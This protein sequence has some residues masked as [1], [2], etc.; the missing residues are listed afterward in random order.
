MIR[1]VDDALNGSH[2]AVVDV[3]HLP[4]FLA[5]SGQALTNK[6]TVDFGKKHFCCLQFSA[7]LFVSAAFL[8]HTSLCLN[9]FGSPRCLI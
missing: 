6:L 4:S 3:F 5:K 7:A 1:H 8:Y 9:L 2:A